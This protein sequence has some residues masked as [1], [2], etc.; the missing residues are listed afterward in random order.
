MT[1]QRSWRQLLL[2]WNGSDAPLLPYYIVAKAWS[3]LLAPLRG[4]GLT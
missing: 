3:D 2:L 4:T 1:I